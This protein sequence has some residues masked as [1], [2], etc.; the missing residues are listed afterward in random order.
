MMEESEHGHIVAR[1]SGLQKCSHDS[2]TTPKLTS[3]SCANAERMCCVL[4]DLRA[5]CVSFFAL[6]RTFLFVLGCSKRGLACGVRVLV[7]I[8]IK[9]YQHVRWLSKEAVANVKV[10]NDD[11]AR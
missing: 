2:P 3:E 8:I 11:A 1:R 6:Y 10:K 4:T 5:P 9:T 7:M